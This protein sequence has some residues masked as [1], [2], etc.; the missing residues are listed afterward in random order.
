MKSARKNTLEKLYF[1]TR[2]FFLKINIGKL[3]CDAI[4][5]YVQPYFLFLDLFWKYNYL[6]I[7]GIT[8]RNMEVVYF[9]VSFFRYGKNN[10]VAERLIP[11]IWNMVTRIS[12]L[13]GLWPH[14]TAEAKLDDPSHM[15]IVTLVLLTKECKNSLF[16]IF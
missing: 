12:S 13:C 4:V 3:H 15:W 6:V 5:R 2:I 11:S 1:K 10:W 16:Q 14:Q 8:D 9:N 7:D